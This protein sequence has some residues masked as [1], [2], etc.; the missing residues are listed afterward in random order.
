MDCCENVYCM[1]FIVRPLLSFVLNAGG[2]F[3]ILV[4]SS[5]LSNPSSAKLTT[6]TGFLFIVMTA[7][8]NPILRGGA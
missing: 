6:S 5:S 8:F 3:W 4:A 1:W 2:R 7:K